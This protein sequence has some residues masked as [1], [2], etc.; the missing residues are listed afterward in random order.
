MATM[1]QRLSQYRPAWRML[2]AF[3]AG[4][5]AN[6]AMPPLN[7]V[8]C[9]WL[10]FP[11]LLWLGSC[12][13]SRKGAFLTG[14][15]F[16][17]GYFV[18]GLYW[19][20]FA[21]LTD[22]ESYWFLLPFAMAGLPAGLAVFPGL[23]ML[24]LH[25]SGFHG[26]GRVFLFA[27]LY[28]TAEWLRGHILTGFPWNLAGYGWSGSLAV[29]QITSVIGIYG[30]SALT[31]LAAA[32][33]ALAADKRISR[34]AGLT[35]ALCGLAIFAGIYTWGHQR[36]EQAERTMTPGIGLKVVQPNIPQVEKW[37]PKYRARNFRRLIELSHTPD[38]GG[39]PVTHIIWPETAIA[40]FISDIPEA[41]EAMQGIIPP[42]GYLMTGQLRQE[43]TV[44]N[45]S[46]PPYFNSLS[47]MDESGQFVAH[48]NK[49]HL[50][51]FGEYIP[52]RNLLPFDPVAAGATNFT[53]GKGPLNL[54]IPK[55][56]PFSP[57]ICYEVIFPGAVIP[58]G[59]KEAPDW[60]L[61]VT[62]DA[63]YRQTAGPHQHLAI[64]RIRS[65]E[66]GIPLVR[67]ANTGISA[68]FDGW[69]RIVA[70]LKLGT[71][72][73]I[74]TGLPLDIG[75]RTQYAA[76]RDLIFFI[77]LGCC[78]VFSIIDKLIHQ[79]KFKLSSKSTI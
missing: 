71:Q 8:F 16:G 76:N 20:S 28:A 67:A 41:R 37:A 30:L 7:L 47:I 6:L 53:P 21:L 64:A 50:V 25:I 72:G 51:P 52:L 66:E 48:A 15:M 19:I 29:L 63:W 59:E 62:N 31:I 74:T 36:L 18:M 60:M 39:Q 57:L 44:D 22:L 43:P 23:V 12:N 78:Y 73:A 54:Q 49:T 46:D 68:V 27:S 33:P 14:W 79:Y 75:Y 55:T 1:Q 61:N 24:I 11:L 5:I 9:F 13:T 69:G 58:Q 10:A 4:V 35:L 2:F 40:W 77:L 42:G 3:L 26:L 38:P 34:P 17:F 32:L 56:P 70:S 45:A 65:I